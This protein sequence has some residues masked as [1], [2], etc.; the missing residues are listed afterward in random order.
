MKISNETVL[1][2]GIEPEKQRV[3]EGII[4]KLGMKAKVVGPECYGK[5]IGALVGMRVDAPEEENVK[6]PGEMLVLSG[7]T[8]TRMNQ[9]L[10]ALR[11]EHASVALKA[12]VT[13]QNKIWNGGSLYREIQREHE[14][15]TGQQV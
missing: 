8:S 1:L 13:E 11:E 14:M 9:F 10:A 5:P 3:I 12:A 2:F 7:L 6:I 15:M 4:S